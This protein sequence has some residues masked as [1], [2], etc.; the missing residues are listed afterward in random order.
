[1]QPDSCCM[2][3]QNNKSTHRKESIHL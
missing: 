3:V 2:Q 1:L